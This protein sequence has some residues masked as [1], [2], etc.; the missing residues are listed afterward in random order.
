L[1]NK[2]AVAVFNEERSELRVKAKAQ[3]LRLQNTLKAA[4]ASYA[5]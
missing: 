5:Y 4:T 2:E 1:I 3:I